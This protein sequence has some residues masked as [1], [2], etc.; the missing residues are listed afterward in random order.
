MDFLRPES[1][2]MKK[3][4]GDPRFIPK[5][6]FTSHAALFIPLGGSGPLHTSTR[7]DTSVLGGATGIH[8]PPNSSPSIVT[9]QA[10][11]ALSTPVMVTIPPQLNIF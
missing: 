10:E 2:N 7:E 8:H 11:A 1:S 9:Q 6:G 5:G 4:V 3:L